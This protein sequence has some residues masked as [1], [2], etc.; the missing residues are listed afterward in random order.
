LSRHQHDPLGCE[1]FAWS[2]KGAE[3]SR[4]VQG[5]AAVAPFDRDSLACVDADA[6]EERQGRVCSRRVGIGPLKGNRRPQG[7]PRRVEHAERLVAAKLENGSAS[8]VDTL[9]GTRGEA[10]G[11]PPGLLVAVLLRE[12]RV[13]TDVRDQERPNTRSASFR[14]QDPSLRQRGRS[15]Y[16]RIAQGGTHDRRRT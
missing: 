10:P 2:R 1:D 15:A 16:R 14:S 9:T 8:R 5:A 6:D 11:K 12:R 3:P 13:A 7:L 4:E